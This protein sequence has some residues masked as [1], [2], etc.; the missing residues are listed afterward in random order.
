MGVSYCI[1]VAKDCNR[2]LLQCSLCFAL[3]HACPAAAAAWVIVA[4]QMLS[5]SDG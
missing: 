1:N 5:I 2:Y 3:A 4:V